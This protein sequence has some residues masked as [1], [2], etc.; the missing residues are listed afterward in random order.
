MQQKKMRKIKKKK[1]EDTHSV[2]MRKEKMKFDLT[3]LCA[4][5]G[6]VI[7]S[8]SGK[9]TCQKH[10]ASIET[11]FK[12]QNISPSVQR[13]ALIYALIE[14]G[15]SLTDNER[16]SGIDACIDGMAEAIFNEK[17]D[18]EV[19]VPFDYM[20]QMNKKRDKPEDLAMF[21]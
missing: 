18:N 21:G 12:E 4:V 9:K 13:A 20:E 19:I 17:K 1:K 3:K 2:K 6:K 10:A 15:E 5:I 7:V 16:E 11:Y 14:T 8:R